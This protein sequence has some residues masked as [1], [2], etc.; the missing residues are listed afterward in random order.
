M[1]PDRSDEDDT[2]LGSADRPEPLQQRAVIGNEEESSNNRS[3][4]DN[5]SGDVQDDSLTTVSGDDETS[6]TAQSLC[7][8]LA[9][10]RQISGMYQHRNP[11]SAPPNTT[12]W[13]RDQLNKID[14]I[15]ELPRVVTAC[16]HAHVETVSDG[17]AHTG[18]LASDIMSILGQDPPTLEIIFAIVPQADEIARNVRREDITAAAAASAATSTPSPP[19][20][21]SLAA[22]I[23]VQKSMKSIPPETII[24]E[25]TEI[26]RTVTPERNFSGGASS[27]RGARK[28]NDGLAAA[29]H[30]GAFEEHPTAYVEPMYAQLS[31]E[32]PN[33][34]DN[35]NCIDSTCS[36]DGS[37]EVS[38][39][40]AAYVI[41]DESV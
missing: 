23:T 32:H 35:H 19:P 1:D 14:K 22:A 7:D 28:E 39:P 37:N 3:N 18:E 31:T 11:S 6:V 2:A 15:D 5:H 29:S 33:T 9:Q 24:P 16:V 25:E 20:R 8:E 21:T 27:S 40:I 38:I 12:P 4:H 36:N 10:K 17:A 13:L 41:Q 34:N 30:P 26:Q